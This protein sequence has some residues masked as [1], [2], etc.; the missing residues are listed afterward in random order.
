MSIVMVPL[1]GSPFAEQALPLALTVARR[2]GA[3]LHLV[4]VRASLSLSADDDSDIYMKTTAA[5]IESQ[6]PGTITP[7]VLTDELG[8]LE[9]PPPP[10]DTVAKVLA[11]HARD[12]ADVIVMS[13]HGRGGVKRAWLGSIADALLRIAPC[14]LLLVRPGDV[15]FRIAADADRGINNILIPL[16]GSET[17]EQA[18]PF[19]RELAAAFGSRLTLLRVTSPL[20][21]Q[22]SSDPADGYPLTDPTALGRRTAVHYLHGIAAQLRQR[23]LTV[24]AHVIEELSP[25]PAIVDYANTHG[26]DLVAL[27]TTGAGSI[28]RLLLGSVAD[29]VIRKGETPVLAC[30]TKHMESSAAD[31]NPAAATATELEH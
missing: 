26:V 11:N 29:H 22:L 18:I 25:A 28:R 8:A 27:T 6:L 7:W 30:N 12:H 31:D 20:A 5:Q 21:L 9:Y 10:P 17:A 13:T 19:A 24:E 16:D 4:R 1:D 3:R 23:G 2:L 15:K 14:P